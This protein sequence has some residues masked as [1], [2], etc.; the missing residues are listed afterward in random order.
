MTKRSKTPAVI[1]KVLEPGPKLRGEDAKP[2]DEWFEGTQVLTFNE[3]HTILTNLDP[4]YQPVAEFM[5]LSG[6]D[7]HEMAGLTT[8]NIQEGYIHVR[9]SLYGGVQ[10]ISPSSTNWWHR[11][12]GI[13]KAIQKRLCVLLERRSGLTLATNKAGN[14]VDEGFERAW[15]KAQKDKRVTSCCL[16][17]TFIAWSLIVGISRLRLRK[18]CGSKSKPLIDYIYRNNLGRVVDDYDQIRAFFENQFPG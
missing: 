11:D 14:F 16:C 4:W 15:T 9:R 8:Q 2:C 13:T 18:L 1:V 10:Y 17:T 7:I 5:L 6:V 12:I 3:F